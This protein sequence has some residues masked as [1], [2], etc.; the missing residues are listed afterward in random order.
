MQFV[1]LGSEDPLEE[2]METHCSILTWKTPWREEP[3][4]PK[5]HKE[6]GHDWETKHST[7][8]MVVPF[9]VFLRNGITILFS[10][11]VAQ[12][13]IPINSC[14][15]VPFSP[16]L[17]QHVPFVFFIYFWMIATRGVRSRFIVVLICIS[18][19]ISY[20]KH[21]F[22]FLWAIYISSWEKY[23]FSS[24]AHFNFFGY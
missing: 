7:E 23:L 18:L 16:H 19:I 5:D 15:K 22:M 4:H 1:S 13:Y 14:I 21:H 17:P 12:I 9:L 6:F 2:E 10:T 3:L 20:V 11:D 8:H 24:S